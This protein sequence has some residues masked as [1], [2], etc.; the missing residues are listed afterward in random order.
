MSEK[1]FHSSR[2][3]GCARNNEGQH[4]CFI[5]S[6]GENRSQECSVSSV[7]AAYSHSPN[8]RSEVRENREEPYFQN[9]LSKWVLAAFDNLTSVYYESAAG[10][11]IPHWGTLVVSALFSVF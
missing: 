6:G 7:K 1:E 2:I 4:S 9:Q 3:D 5:E 8:E 11:P 10:T